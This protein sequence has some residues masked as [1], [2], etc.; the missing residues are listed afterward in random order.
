MATTDG[1]Y[2]DFFGL[3][4]RPFSLVPD[5]SFLFR[6]DQYSRALTM[7]EYGI[8]TRAPVTL[9]TGEVGAGKT[10]VLHALLATL[11]EDVL[12][13]L[14]MNSHGARGELL[15]WVLMSLGQRVPAGASYVELFCQFQE[16]LIG[17]YA[18]RRRV[19]LIFDEAQ[20]LSRE[21]LEELRMLTNINSNRD[22]LLQLVLVGQ[23]ELRDTVRR[24]DMVQ[25]AQ[26]IAMSFH[27]PAMN[28]ATVEGYID[29]RLS[30][31]GASARIFNSPAAKLVY[32]A[33]GGVPRL[34]NQL[35]DLAMVYAFTKDE[36]FVSRQTVKEVLSDGVFFAGGRDVD[37]GTLPS[38][39]PV[40]DVGY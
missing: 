24:P 35:C 18:A 9:M 38:R 16:F 22:E 32:H 4:V 29:H 17:E 23:P 26:R 30:V 13:G 34:I 36:H 5:P 33:T 3:S 40:S 27:I 10:T 12:A 25:L 11:G 28:A 20:N 6:A 37:F 1:I 19:I 15:Q 31:A 2:L 39:G 14:I 7:L 8:V 21:S